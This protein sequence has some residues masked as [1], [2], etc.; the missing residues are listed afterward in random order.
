MSI[1]GPLSQT[2][3]GIQTYTSILLGVKPWLNDP[4][5]LPMPWRSVEPKRKLKLA[6]LWDDGIVRPTPPVRRALKET[7]QKLKQA[8]HEIIDWEPLAHNEMLAILVSYEI[9]IYIYME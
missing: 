8:G 1:N 7:V 2:L 6:V 5:V 4:K 9:Y 3:S